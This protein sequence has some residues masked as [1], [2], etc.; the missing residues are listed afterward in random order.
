MLHKSHVRG[1][2][3]QMAGSVRDLLAVTLVPSRATQPG[4]HPS[5]AEKT[6]TKKKAFSHSAEMDQSHS[7]S[8]NTSQR[9]RRVHTADLKVKETKCI[10]SLCCTEGCAVQRGAVERSAVQRGA[11]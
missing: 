1:H 8:L 4:G 2:L 10:V 9:P 6:S 11:V 3:G 5:T 7:N